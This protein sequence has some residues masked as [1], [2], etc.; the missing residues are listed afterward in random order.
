[1]HWSEEHEVVRRVILEVDPMD[2][3]FEEDDNVDEYDPEVREIVK[4]L[5]E[6]KTV[7]DL[8]VVVW[9]VFKK[10][11]SEEFVGSPD[12]Y[13]RIAQRIFETQ[14]SPGTKP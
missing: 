5:P 2:L 10:F 12:R 8:T 11:F 7:D 13:R 14:P 9:D 6:A 1:M 3:Y 4:R